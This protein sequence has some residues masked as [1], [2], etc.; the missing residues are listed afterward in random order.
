MDRAA[1][2]VDAGYL[3]TGAGGLLLGTKK[4]H[5]IGCEF[6]KIVSALVRYAE[7]RSNRP[8]LRL[9]W[10][11]GAPQAVPLPEHLRV[12]QLPFVKL[13]LGRVVGPR[14]NRRQKGVDSLIVRDLIVLAEE[15]AISAVNRLLML[16]F[17]SSA[18]AAGEPAVP[19]AQGRFGSVRRL[20]CTS[21]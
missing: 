21:R 2:L 6:S 19:P 14:D 3:L 15:R 7:E 9:Y 18:C 13:R 4:R 20:P 17:I 12:A 5:E 1:V 8:V 11:D 16:A 10:Y